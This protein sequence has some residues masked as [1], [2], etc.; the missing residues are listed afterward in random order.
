M[1]S[2]PV[3]VRLSPAGRILLN[4]RLA[5]IAEFIPF[6]FGRKIISTSRKLLCGDS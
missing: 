3:N 2:G 6:E 5:E 4:N 1:S